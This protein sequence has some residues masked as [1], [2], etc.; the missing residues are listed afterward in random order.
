[1]IPVYL[2]GSDGK[3]VTVN[4]S[5]ELQVVFGDY[6][7]TKFN[8]L[9]LVDTAYNYY[10]PR[11]G[12]QFVMTGMLCF[13]DKEVSDTS[14]TVIIIYE[15]SEPDTL[16]VDRVLLQFGMGKLTTMPFPN[17][18][19]LVNEGAYVNAK[20]SDDDIHL[21]IVGHYISTVQK[22]VEV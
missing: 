10:G 8:E 7:L 17:V 9:D 5:G 22:P 21:N 18:R 19:I 4:A 11:V 20:T 2:A 1:M 16:T 13:A 6:D 3:Q 15:A 12:K 14:D